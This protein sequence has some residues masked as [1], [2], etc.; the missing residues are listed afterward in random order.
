MIRIVAL[1]LSLALAFGCSQSFAQTGSVLTQS[2][3]N[4]IIGQPG[5]SQPSCLYPDNNA[6]LITPFILRQGL[7]DVVATM[8]SS[9]AAG[10]LNVG[11][12]AITNGNSTATQYGVL[13]DKHGALGDSNG[14]PSLSNGITGPSVVISGN[15]AP[16]PNIASIIG[17]GI[18]APLVLATADGGETIFYEASFGTNSNSTISQ[19]KARGTAAN[20]Q[21][22]LQGDVIG[23]LEGIGWSSTG[24]LGGA[25]A[26]AIMETR[27]IENFSP[28]TN[29]TGY[30][31]FIQ[32]GGT[33]YPTS[34]VS[35]LQINAGGLGG[36]TIGG[37][38]GN[39][40]APDAQDFGI[41]TVS[42]TGGVFVNANAASMQSGPSG[43][44]FHT[45]QAD[46]TANYTI[47]DAF[48]NAP[49]I[50]FR[51]ADGTGASPSAVQSNDVLGVLGA[52]G[53]GASGYNS[54]P[55]ANVSFFAAQN[56]TGSA[57][58]TYLD[59]ITTANG[60]I[61]RATA[62][63]AENDGGI[64]LAP[65]TN[66]NPSF[67]LGSLGMTGALILDANASAS[68]SGPTGTLVH[69]SQA[70]TLSNSLL[71]DA[72]ANNANITLRRADTTAASPSAVQ[73]GDQIGTYGA[74][75]FNGSA[76]TSNR[77]AIAVIAAQNW[78]VGNNGT[79]LDVYTTPLNSSTNT[80]SARHF[81]SGGIGIGESTADPGTGAILPA[82]QAFASLTSCS[83]T[84]K[85]ALANVTDSTTNTWGATITGSGGDQVLAYCDGSNWTVAAK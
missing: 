42:L 64:V 1:A 8:F 38:G 57:Q 52:Y 74:A 2:Q 79:N 36:V 27:A 84:I 4:A 55:N 17:G 73:S 9:Q 6:N 60:G 45:A 41:G 19:Q 14:D 59:L 71:L 48:A 54:E 53:Y 23:A 80:I 77:A 70:D 44:T 51:R 50:I 49:A 66:P 46:S 20:P 5:C 26:T 47:L 81:P 69:I 31:F 37:V 13:F 61:I 7:L 22:L 16:I 83:S 78:T 85:G 15:A 56:W 32:L 3:L 18:T 34:A 24:V 68:L 65:A 39:F 43:T 35:A 11:V 10:S 67:G 62:L 75:G 33:A 72:Y 30:F 82:N 25:P 28:T 58:G 12:S 63:R 29:G 21:P 40:Y 76:Y